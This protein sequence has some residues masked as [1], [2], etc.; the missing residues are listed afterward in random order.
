MGE[1]YVAR[2]P[3]PHHPVAALKRLRPDVA[4]VPTFAERFQHEAEL[5][6]RL[7]HPNVVATLD[8]GSVDGQLYVA[9]E[10]VMGKDTGYVADRLRERGQ[11]GPA[12][13]GVRLLLDGLAGLAYVHGAQEADGKPLRLVHR[14]MTPGNLLVGYDG[15]ARLADFGLAKSLL[16][17]K[18]NLTNHGE[19]LGTPHYLPPEVVRGES[20]GPAA[21]LYGLG[22]VTYRFLTGIAP[23]QG[24]TAEVLMKVLSEAPRPLGELRPDLPPWL[25]T[26]VH[27]LMEKDPR[28]RPQDAT[29]LFELLQAEARGAGLL[30]GR[31]QVG[32]WLASLFAPEHEEERA[33]RER[34]EQLSIDELDAQ[35]EGTVVLARPRSDSRLAPPSSLAAA[36]DEGGTDLALS[37]D[38]V[39]AAGGEPRRREP[40]AALDFAPGSEETEFAQPALLPSRVERER[41]SREPGELRPNRALEA[42]D[43][44]MPT[45]AVTLA[46]GS[47]LGFGAV[48]ED[49]LDPS[50]ATAPG[51]HDAPV[52]P[53]FVDEPGRREAAEVGDE[54]A[55]PFR[56]RPRN[57]ESVM[58][59]P[60]IGGAKPSFEVRR[61]PA[62]GTDPTTFSSRGAPK[63]RPRPERGAPSPAIAASPG[64]PAALFK[65]NAPFLAGLLA[66]AV[67]LGIGVGALLASLRPVETVRVGPAAESPL[68]RRFIDLRARIDARRARGEALPPALDGHVA[69]AASA[70][71]AGDEAAAARAL[72]AAEAAL[73]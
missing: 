21:D 18:S 34:I 71:V 30:V 63:P 65:K 66:L 48:P 2:T 1:V 39:A 46:P 31:P 35:R 52:L 7:A 58:V 12:A 16:T 61:T 42:L 29:P 6:V 14:D 50:D 64:S 72:D 67:G 45:Q 62:E 5:S 26:F 8:V 11:G 41:R 32:R 53:G 60:V 36:G 15:I 69:D 28:R 37:L 51:R 57:P 22:A 23:H 43:E 59:S 20:A 24:S 56:Q 4:K 47:L 13:V 10:L 40:S 70:L 55:A 49:T 19:I 54:A 38:A 68:R 73:R 27:R 9:S 17:E 44:G 3:W 25:A 33:E